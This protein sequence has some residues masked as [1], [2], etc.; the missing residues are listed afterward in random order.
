MTTN[1]IREEV[2]ASLPKP[3]FGTNERRGNYDCKVARTYFEKCEGL[4][5]RGEFVSLQKM[6]WEVMEPNRMI[7]IFKQC[8]HGI[9]RDNSGLRKLIK[10]TILKILERQSN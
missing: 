1:Q 6:R 4:N 7:F 3:Q 5:N 2:I 10:D 9:K 8:L